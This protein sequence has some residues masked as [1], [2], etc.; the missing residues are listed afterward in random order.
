MSSSLDRSPGT[1]R[2]STPVA[3]R[4]F[5]RRRLQFL[6]VAAA[7]NEIRPFLGQ[8]IGAS[9]AK[10]LAAAANHGDSAADS[11]VHR[12][13]SNRKLALCYQHAGWVATCGFPES[14]PASGCSA[15]RTQLL[16]RANPCHPVASNS[17]QTDSSPSCANAQPAT[18]CPTTQ[19]I[20]YSQTSSGTL[21]RWDLGILASVNKS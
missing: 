9:P 2:T 3:A 12:A 5:R 1:T 11:K 8:R 7:D 15:F 14:P 10:P 4:Y 6:C 20:P 17:T 18:R 21:S 16:R 13:P 19:A